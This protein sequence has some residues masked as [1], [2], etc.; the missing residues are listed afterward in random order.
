MTT[1]RTRPPFRADQVGS[2]LRPRK[3]LDA[4]QQWKSGRLPIAELTALED[5]AIRE[6]VVMQES[7][8]LKSITD[9]EFRRDDWYLD[10]IERPSAS[11]GTWQLDGD[12]LL[13]E[14]CAGLTYDWEIVTVTNKELVMR[15]SGASED[16]VF[17]R[18]GP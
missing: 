18:I 3:L 4:R 8:G 2:L 10:F 17:K 1:L 15:E 5:A 12:R 13:V 11:G 9:G 6:A 14:C 16:T 7:I